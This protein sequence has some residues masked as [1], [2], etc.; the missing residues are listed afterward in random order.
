MESLSSYLKYETKVIHL[1]KEKIKSETGS[2]RNIMVQY[3]YR[4]YFFDLV[5]LGDN[6]KILKIYEIKSHSAI[7][8]NFEFIVQIFQNFKDD[9]INE[10]NVIFEIKNIL[11]NYPQIN[12]LFETI[13]II[14]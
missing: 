5:E 12:N 2:E 11:Q 10:E 9:K 1:L 8:R 7:K 3:K 14:K 4:S 6:D 13:F